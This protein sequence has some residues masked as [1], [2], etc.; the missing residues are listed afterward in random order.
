MGSHRASSLESNDPSP[1]GTRRPDTQHTTHRSPASL[2]CLPLWF[3][4]PVAL[5][6]WQPQ[7]QTLL[8]LSNKNFTAQLSS[9][10]MKEASRDQSQQV[11]RRGWGLPQSRSQV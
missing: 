3:G 2:S 8:S 5:F 1:M 7:A 9:E 6:N 10:A 11:P 4:S